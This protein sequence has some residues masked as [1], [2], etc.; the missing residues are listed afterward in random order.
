MGFF[1][2]RPTEP[3]DRAKAAL[4]VIRAANTQYE[5]NGS[6]LDSPKYRRATGELASLGA[7]VVPLLI[8][9]LQTP[10]PDGFTGEAA[11][12]K[13]VANDI[14]EALGAIGDARA[15]GPLMEAGRHN[16][17]MAPR[18]LTRFPEGLEAL[19]AGLDD[20]DEYVRAN[21]ISGLAYGPNAPTDLPQVVKRMLSDESGWVRFTAA[22]V[23]VGR[24][25]ADP[26]LVP[27]LSEMIRED[28][29]E[30][31]RGMAETALA[32]LSRTA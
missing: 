29:D 28:P 20:P 19:F 17:E 11:I 1:T 24:E 8:D 30:M 13:G 3:A 21:C 14:A 5:T 9:A 32:G 25:I 27:L 18:A 4:A 12:E 7:D 6:G 23:V 26:E 10:R 22:Q 31:A 15:V 16:I 2:R